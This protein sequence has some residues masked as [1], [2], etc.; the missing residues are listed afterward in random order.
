MTKRGSESF[1]IVIVCHQNLS[2]LQSIIITIR[3]NNF[4]DRT[5]QRSICWA[6]EK[7]FESWKNA[8]S[9]WIHLNHSIHNHVIT[10]QISCNVFRYGIYLLSH[11]SNACLLS[12]LAVSLYSMKS[13]AYTLILVLRSS[14]SVLMN[15]EHMCVH[16]GV[17]AFKHIAKDIR[18]KWNTAFDKLTIPISVSNRKSY[19]MGVKD[20]HLS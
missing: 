13:L 17:A 20:L 2:S 19:F 10:S 15:S 4:D 11:T 3:N 1:G 8:K 18:L 12:L 7:A 16:R 6:F 5:E 9:H 14:L